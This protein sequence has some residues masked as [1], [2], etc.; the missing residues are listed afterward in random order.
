LLNTFAMAPLSVSVNYMTGDPACMLSV[1]DQATSVH[2]L[3]AD[4]SK[5]LEQPFYSIRL[6]LAGADTRVLSPHERLCD[7]A[8]RHED[9]ISSALQLQVVVVSTLGEAG[10]LLKEVIRSTAK[11]HSLPTAFVADKFIEPIPTAE[12]QATINSVASL[13]NGSEDVGLPED[14]AMWMEVLLRSP[15]GEC[16]E[17]A[18]SIR[19]DRTR[20]GLPVE[21]MRAGATRDLIY[22]SVIMSNDLIVYMVDVN[23]ELASLWGLEPTPCGVWRAEVSADCFDVPDWFTV[24]FWRDIRDR[25]HD[26]VAVPTEPKRVAPDLATFFSLWA[27]QG[28]VPR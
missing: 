21:V 24:S 19:I 8:H 27:G 25:K 26:Q 13:V 5:A 23:G 6:M 11:K 28:A 14:M 17:D 18:D 3:S 20:F 1:D 4:V 16:V 2:E 12:V 22:L 7:L 15:Q 10:N 9:G